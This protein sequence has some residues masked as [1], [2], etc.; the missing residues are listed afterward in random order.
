MRTSLL[1]PAKPDITDNLDQGVRKRYSG[2]FPQLQSVLPENS[3]LQPWTL[4]EPGKAGGEGL[5]MPV[6]L[7]CSRKWQE[8]GFSGDPSSLHYS[9]KRSGDLSSRPL[10]PGRAP[11]SPMLGLGLSSVSSVCPAVWDEWHTAWFPLVPALV[12]FTD[13]VGEG[14]QITLTGSYLI[15]RAKGGHGS[16]S[17]RKAWSCLNIAE[18]TWGLGRT[19]IIHSPGAAATESRPTQV[20]CGTEVKAI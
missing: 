2:D 7:S 16:I 18:H 1:E 6:C 15:S 11:R 8:E 12:G 20:N 17:T 4:S 9:C 5:S 19:G 3:S 13:E 14:G 10:Q